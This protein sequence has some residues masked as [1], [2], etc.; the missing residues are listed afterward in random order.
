MRKIFLLFIALVT[1]LVADAFYY[2][3]LNFY[4]NTDGCEL[5]GFVPNYIVPSSA[6]LH[7]PSYAYDDNGNAYKVNRIANEAFKG[8]AEIEQLSI[9]AT[10]EVIGAKAFMSCIN[11]KVCELY[12]TTKEIRDEAFFGCISLVA[13]STCA[14]RIGSDA[15]KG[16]TALRTVY[17]GAPMKYIEQG[18]FMGCTALTNIDIPHTVEQIGGFPRTQGAFEDCLSLMSVTFSYNLSDKKPCLKRIDNYSFKNCI[19][20]ERLDFPYSLT[21]VGIDAFLRCASLKHLEWGGPQE[22]NVDKN[23]FTGVPLS[24]IVYHGN[25]RLWDASDFQKL[26]FLKEVRYDTYATQVQGGI[27]KNLSTLKEVHLD[28]VTR[29]N[30]SAFMNCTG[31]TEV[32]LSNIEVIENDAFNNC[33]NL[34]EVKF[35]DKITNIPDCLSKSAITTLN[36][37][38]N[39][40]SFATP[41]YCEKLTTVTI[42]DGVEQCTGTFYGC[43]SL[44]SLQFGKNTV[45][46]SI[47]PKSVRK[48]VCANPV[49][50]KTGNFQKEVY[51]LGELIVPPGASEAYRNALYW[52]SFYRI[53]EAE[54]GAV[55]SVTTDSDAPVI[56]T[57]DGYIEVL[58]TRPTAIYSIDGKLIT[59]LKKGKHRISPDKG[60]YILVSGNTTKKFRI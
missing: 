25:V 49:P 26:E 60:V 43:S 31:L 21:H 23:D 51:E 41:T 14:E 15:F 28:K 1:S 5:R 16:C 42:G 30:W 22:I 54:I 57:G 33:T 13:L 52:K 2:N 53:I 8:C 40:T 36:I 59:L 34:T 4:P 32:D 50:P 35:G 46:V 27:Y 29:I 11:L 39:V 10:V 45:S 37:P 55:E 20:L 56:T 24:R 19:A 9:P 44:Y 12:P 7:I 47:Q 48:V 6:S 58:S 38:D 18:A 3:N 17:L